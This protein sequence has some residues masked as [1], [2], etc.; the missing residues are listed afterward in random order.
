MLCQFSLQLPPMPASQPRQL[1]CLPAFSCLPKP[2]A[3]PIAP[4][5]VGTLKKQERPKIKGNALPTVTTAPNPFPLLPPC[6]PASLPAPPFLPSSTGLRKGL[7]RKVGEG[8][9]IKY[10]IIIGIDVSRKMI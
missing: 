1:P 2:P 10:V 4:A 8:K 7:R 5:I 3:Q 6:L 9:V